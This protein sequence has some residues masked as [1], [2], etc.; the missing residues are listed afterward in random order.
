MWAEK[1]YDNQFAGLSPYLD[2]CCY[3]HE[4]D[5]KE[6]PWYPSGAV[7][8]GT[9][10]RD[11]ETKISGNVS[12]RISTKGETPCHLGISQDGVA[13]DAKKPCQFRCY[14]KQDGVRGPVKVSVHREGVILASAEILPGNAWQ[15]H[16]TRLV[17]SSTCEN[18]TL[19]ISFSGPGTLWLDNVTLM[20]E[21]TV[22]GWRCDVVDAIK[23]LRPGCIRFGGCA[24]DQGLGGELFSW[25]EAL[26]DPDLRRPFHAW[27]GL[28]PTGPGLEEIVQ[29]CGSVGAEPLICI[30][31]EKN[32]PS[33]AA[34]QVQY[35]N[36]AVT[37]PMGALRARNGHPAPYNIRYWQVGNERGED[38]Y[39][40][41]LPAF[42]AAIKAED[43]S[44]I[45]LS[46]YPKPAVLQGAGKYLDIVCP[47]HYSPDLKG[48]EEDFKRI[49]TLIAEYAPAGKSIGVG[50]T[51]WNSTGGNWGTERAMLWTLENAL[52]CARYQ[53]LMH[54][55]CDLVRL[56]N[57]SNLSNS[58][59]SGAIQTDRS[60][61]YKTPAYFAQALYAEHV[62]ARPLMIET[63]GDAPTELDISATWCKAHNEMVVYVVNSALQAIS[64]T[65][66]FSAHGVS[67]RQLTVWT[68]AD[69]DRAGEPDVTNS[70]DDP[71][72]V[73][74]V[75]SVVTTDTMALT[76]R[77][78]ALSLTVL[79][80][81]G[82]GVYDPSGE[83]GVVLAVGSA[84][85]ARHLPATGREFKG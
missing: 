66:D 42:C 63:S 70:F 4:T 85:A 58:L 56:S 60:R 44:A 10:L 29:L 68:L 69:R 23:G 7:N 41:L 51:E 18:A 34:E 79:T 80:W 46:S 17:F 55:N 12:M 36:G 78:P 27:G 64:Q 30:G 2:W 77:F 81:P 37:T 8:R 48:H 76:Y 38:V 26:G 24:V 49:R 11:P 14:L 71:D 22:G 19:S 72:R 57:R 6:H 75:R 74:P 33:G 82:A 3:L 83:L 16:Q 67:A 5:F 32:T 13:V 39:A 20:P 62:P 52:Y 43:P 50:V 25:R 65:L 45:L 15:K 84:Q 9:W 59:C 28:Q 1:L 35:F 53:N 40:E 61:L 47:H 21:E 31:F 54:A 73:K